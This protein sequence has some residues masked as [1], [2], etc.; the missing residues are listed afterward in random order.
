MAGSLLG[1]GVSAINNAQ[2]SL[3]TTQHNISNANSAGFHRQQT[4]QTSNIAQATGAGYIGSGAHVQTIQRQYDQ[5]LDGQVMSAATQSKF[6][7]AYQSQIQQIDDLLADP[8]TGLSPAIQ[9]FF[10]GVSAVANDPTSVAARQ[11]L[12]ST[13]ETL[14]ARFKSLYTRIDDIRGGIN[15]QLSTLV[16]SINSFSSQIADLNGKIAQAQSLNGQ[17]PNDLMDQRDQVISNLNELVKTTVVRQSD[18]AYNVFIGNGQSLVTGSTAFTLA[19]QNDANDPTQKNIAYAV[20]NGYATIPSANLENGGTLGGLLAFRRLS[21]DSAQNA[22]GR[23]ALALA[24]T[25][26]NQSKLGQD[27]N[28]VL[29]TNFF[30][31]A[32]TSPSV[33]SNSGNS[34]SGAAVI[35]ATL[36]SSAAGA[37][38]TSNYSLSYSSASSNY[39][40]TQLSDGSVT[41]IA[42]SA[43]PSTT[44]YGFTIALSSGTPANG[45]QWLITPTRFGARDIS[46]A[47]TDPNAIAAAAP[48]RS[49]ATASNTGAGSISLASV[50]TA[51]QPP[52]N[53]A[54]QHTVTITFTS[55]TTFNVV[56]TTLGSTLATG[57]T[58]TS[59]AALSYNGW[60]TAISGTPAS[61]DSF[62][63]ATNTGGVG[64][65]RNALALAGLQTSNLLA[66]N[67]SGTPTTTYQGAYA[68]MVSSVGNTTAQMKTNSAAQQTLLDNATQSQ[69][70]LSG[71]NLDEEAANLLRFQQAYQAAAKMIQI[72][73]TLFDT[74]L[75][76]Q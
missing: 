71:V 56:D 43:L 28:G 54:I 6:Y 59:G 15:T 38:S 53:S 7:D 49:A 72:G 36:V 67:S 16:T 26:N 46:V 69:Q 64:D 31:I 44:S 48:I 42:A 9:T 4:L 47:L 60:T 51:S 57:S 73:S 17:P 68:Q 61:G 50:N 18:G 22:L 52:L 5:F 20:G 34:S 41:T 11:S 32:S 24:Q 45:D 55:A 39:T 19:L 2:L 10:T 25:F 66:N 30:N 65:N 1:I 35:G 40:L 76:I 62:T 21:L 37:L 29:G 12:L 70:A 58:Y 27:L 8:N 13:G 23:V 14:V 33:L 74:I 75:A 3:L 63:V